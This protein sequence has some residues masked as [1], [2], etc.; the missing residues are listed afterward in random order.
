MSQKIAAKIGCGSFDQFDMQSLNEYTFFF[1]IL[2][3]KFSK[4]LGHVIYRWKGVF[5]T[6][7][8][9]ILHAPKILA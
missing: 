7:S 1:F 4:D 3:L 6:F 8:Y 2:Q 5:K 9:G